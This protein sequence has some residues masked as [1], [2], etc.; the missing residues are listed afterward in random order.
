MIALDEL[1]KLPIG[2]RIQIVEELTRSIHEEEGD[3]GESPER[4]G[5]LRE[6]YAAHLADPSSAEPWELVLE[7]IRSERE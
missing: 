1:K 4:I 7:H 6:R 2:E 3:F 5:E